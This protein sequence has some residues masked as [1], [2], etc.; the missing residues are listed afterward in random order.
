MCGI[1]IVS[2]LPLPLPLLPL[3][4]CMYVQAG[5]WKNERSKKNEKKKYIKEQRKQQ[6]K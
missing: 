3:V 5:K 6:K 2:A 1:G 4:N